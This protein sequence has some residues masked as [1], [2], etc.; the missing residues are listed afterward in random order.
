MHGWSSRGGRGSRDRK[1]CR[2][3]RSRWRRP[4]HLKRD[5]FRG[6]RQFRRYFRALR[7]RTLWAQAWAQTSAIHLFWAKAHTPSSDTS[8]P[9]WAQ[10][11]APARVERLCL[12]LGHPRSGFRHLVRLEL[13]SEKSATR[14]RW[15]GNFGHDLAGKFAHLDRR[16]RRWRIFAIQCTGSTVVVVACDTFPDSSQ[17]RN[18]SW[19]W[20]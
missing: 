8:S 13:F 4:V 2:D 10:A 3:R 20:R 18:T 19:R 12:F 14:C 9:P 5:A 16:P 7:V 15:L 6:R 17:R 11:S 1:S